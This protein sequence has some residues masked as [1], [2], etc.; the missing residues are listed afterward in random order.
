M[1][2]KQFLQR[3]LQRKIMLVLAEKERGTVPFKDG[4]ASYG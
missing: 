1:A 4:Y 2:A 3:A